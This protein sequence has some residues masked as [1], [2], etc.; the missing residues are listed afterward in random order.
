MVVSDGTIAAYHSLMDLAVQVQL[1][2]AVMRAAGG[3][4]EEAVVVVG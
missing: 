3:G 1:L 2:V 4:I